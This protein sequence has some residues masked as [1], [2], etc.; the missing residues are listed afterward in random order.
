[1]HNELLSFYERELSF[2]RQM[3]AEF[4]SK[5]PKIAARLQL[6]PDRCE[7]P[8]TER[9][10][11]GF[12]L[13]A[14]RV[15]LKLEDEFPE[16]TQ[17]FLNLV[18]PHYTRPIPSISIAQLLV[19]PEKTRAASDFVV[20]RGTPLYSKPVDGIP[21]E[22]RSCYDVRLWPVS[23]T[24]GQWRTPERLDPPVRAPDAAAVIQLNLTAWPDVV[25]GNL[26]IDTLRF[27]LA[28]DSG[29][30]NTVYELLCNNCVRILLREPDSKRKGRVFELPGS[31]LRPIGFDE[32]EALLPFPRKSFGGYRILQEYFAFPEKFFFFDLHGLEILAEAGVEQQV[33]I[34]FLLAPYERAERNQLL[35][36]AVTQKMFRLGCTPVVNLFPR[37]AEPIEVSQTHVEY[38]VIPDSRRPDSF[39]VFS[40]DQVSLTTQ[41]TDQ[42][43]PFEPLYSLRHA[44]SKTSRG[45]Y[46][47]NRKANSEGDSRTDMFLTLVDIT[48]ALLTLDMDTLTVRCT[49]SN[50]NLPSKLPFGDEQGDLTLDNSLIHRVS[51]LRKPTPPARYELNHGSLWR[52]ISHLSLNYLSLVEEGRDALQEILSLYQT[53]GGDRQVEGITGVASSRHFAGLVSENGISNVRG[54]KVDVELD[55]DFFVGGGVYLF[56]SV[57]EHFFAQYVSLNSFSQLRVTTK[58]RKEVLREWAPRAGN[59]T[60]L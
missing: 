47:V 12:A 44:S 19:D 52:L 25:L 38:P 30:V 4:V 46:H 2:L 48:G 49:C 42:V 14:A 43:I 50:G 40:V 39:E 9:L 15:H 51:I 13:L 57:I 32:N 23:I 60:L 45:F 29:V 34:L 20:E 53:S 27:H 54:T 10:L 8:H 37:T 59:R 5:Y 7:D 3:G 6:E 36:G 18:F 21:C 33:E 41:H 1:M 56:S 11:E 58:Q 31:N 22:F 26:S 55:E 35:E 24:G 28:G 17:A 16:I